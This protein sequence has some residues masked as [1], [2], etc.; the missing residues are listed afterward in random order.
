[1]QMNAQMH[2]MN[3]RM[4]QAQAMNQNPNVYQKPPQMHQQAHE[5][6]NGFPY[7]SPYQRVPYMS[8]MS[9]PFESQA[10]PQQPL[11]PMNPLSPLHQQMNNV[12]LSPPQ[13]KP[14]QKKVSFGPDTKLGSDGNNSPAPSTTSSASDVNNNQ[15]AVTSQTQV[16]PTKIAFNS[17]PIVKSTAKTSLCN[18]C[19]KQHTVGT[20]LY[21]ANCDNYLSRFN[22]TVRR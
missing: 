20:S 13:M 16:I 4:Y 2:M 12:Y 9:M 8:E 21:C 14:T 1:M 3:A 18:L 15:N 7:Q 22:A 10:P 17:A 5:F 11:N 6:Q 19:R